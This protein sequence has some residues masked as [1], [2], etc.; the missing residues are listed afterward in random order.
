[1]F[2]EASIAQALCLRDVMSMY[3]ALSQACG[4]RPARCRD[5]RYLLGFPVSV[6]CLTVEKVPRYPIH[7]SA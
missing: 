3:V 4:H 5:L 7:S 1:M 6:L 2:A